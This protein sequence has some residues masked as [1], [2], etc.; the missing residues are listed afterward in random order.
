MD[1]VLGVGDRVVN[2]P[3]WNRRQALLGGHVC[4]DPQHRDRLSRISFR[5]AHDPREDDPRRRR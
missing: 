3:N 2:E 1:L 5:E 4:A